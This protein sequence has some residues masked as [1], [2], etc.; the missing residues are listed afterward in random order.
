MLNEVTR[1]C[2]RGS[3]CDRD[4]TR[5]LCGLK[6]VNLTVLRIGIPCPT[7]NAQSVRAHSEKS[8]IGKRSSVVVL[9]LGIPSVTSYSVTFWVILTIFGNGSR[10]GRDVSY[11]FRTVQTRFGI[12]GFSADPNS[13]TDKQLKL[14]KHSITPNTHH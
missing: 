11:H 5:S 13:E 8:M 12:S 6:M 3:I 7:H 9:I 4:G 10:T 2:F 1:I 14:N